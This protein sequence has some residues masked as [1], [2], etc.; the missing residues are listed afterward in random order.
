MRRTISLLIILSIVLSSAFS[1]AFDDSTELP[2]PG[3]DLG[4]IILAQNLTIS[5][6]YTVSGS[7]TWGHVVVTT[8]GK[9]VVPK[10][11]VLNGTSILLKGNSIL[12]VS[13]GKVNLT[14]SKKSGSVS[15]SGSCKH[16]NVTKGGI[17][18]LKGSNGYADTS[19]NGPYKSYISTSMGGSAK[20]DVIAST[21]LNLA[22]ATIIASGGDGF[23]LP[24]STSAA[25]NAWQKG[26][27][28]SGYAASGGNSSIWMRT[29]SPNAVKIE[30]SVLQASAG[31]GGDASKGGDG[32][33][34]APGKG[35]GYCNGGTVQGHV[36]AGGNADVSLCVNASLSIEHTNIT[37]SAGNGGKAGDGGK[38]GGVWSGGGGGG[39][40]GGDATNGASNAGYG[41]AKGDVGSGGDASLKIESTKLVITYCNVT[42]SG[43]TGGEAGDGGDGNNEGGGGGAGYGGGGGIGRS[44]SGKVCGPG[45]AAERVGTGGSATL[46]LVSGHIKIESSKLTAKAGNGGNAGDGGDGFWG[47]GFNGGGGGGGG[48]GGGGGAGDNVRGAKGSVTN[49]VGVGGSSILKFN[50]TTRIY[51]ISSTLVAVGGNGGGSGNGGLGPY[52]GG[53]GGGYGGAGGGSGGAYNGGSCTVSGTVGNGGDATLLLKG[54]PC[55]GPTSKLNCT[56][57]KKGDGKTSKGGGNCG[58]AGTGR[59]TS[60]GK[61]Y[62]TIPMCI[63]LLISPQNGSM[64]SPIFRYFAHNSTT[65][66]TVTGYTIQVDNDQN[67]SSPVISKTTKA[68]SITIANLSS[69]TYYWRVRAYYSS[70]A[71]STAGWSDV[72]IFYV[73]IN[74]PPRLVNPLKDFTMLEDTVDNTSVNLTGIFSDPEGD[75]LRYSVSGATNI[76]V[77]ILSN[78]SVVFTPDQDWTGVEEITFK[79]KDPHYHLKPDPIDTVN[80][81]VQNVN[82]PP[83]IISHDNINSTEDE[84]YEVQYDAEDID[85]TNDTLLW[86]MTSNSTFLIIDNATGLL[87]GTPRNDDV[88][89]FWVNITVSDGN[90]GYDSSNFTLTVF[91]TNDPPEIITSH[92][93]TCYENEFYSVEYTATDIDPTADVFTW[94]LDTTCFF[95]TMDPA[96]ILFGKPSN[97][98]VGNHHVSISVSDGK[99]GSTTS[100]FTLTVINVNDAP[101]ITTSPRTTCMEDEHYV[102]DFE[103][104]DIDPTADVFEWSIET[105]ASFLTIDP[106]EGVLSGTPENDDVGN[107][108]VSVRVS[109]GRGG[110][111]VVNFTLAVFNVND[112]PVILTEDCT[113]CLEDESYSVDYEAVDLDPTLDKL[114][115]GMETNAS[116]LNMDPQTGCLTGVP[117]NWDVGDYWVK[118]IVSDG[119]GGLMT[120][121][122]FLT[123]LAVNDPPIVAKVP[124]VVLRED[125]PG[126]IDLSSHVSDEDTPTALLNLT[127]FHYGIV[128]VSG[129]ELEMLYEVWLEDHLVTFNVSDGESSVEGSF[130]VRVIGINDPPEI[131]GL[132]PHSPPIYIV[133]E[134]GTELWLPIVFEDEDD[135]Q[136]HFGVT[137]QWN[138]VQAYDNGTVRIQ[139]KKGELG[140][141]EATVTVDDLKG[142]FATIDLT[143]EVIN[144]NDPPSVKILSPGNGTMYEFGQNVTFNARISDPDIVIGDELTL[145]WTS[146]ISGTL[147]SL[148]LEDDLEFRLNGLVE[149][150]HRITATVSDGNLSSSAWLDLT[151]VKKSEPDE[152]DE[153]RVFLRPIE[154]AI[155]VLIII[156]TA[157]LAI[158]RVYRRQSTVEDDMVEPQPEEPHTEEVESSDLEPQGEDDHQDIEIE[159]R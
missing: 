23:D 86:A 25:C 110:F 89:I 64:L 135:D 140:Q 13:G 7:E 147:K 49:K 40:C 104:R 24:K 77:T 18:L 80:V 19:S 134:E 76:S 122:F 41:Y 60:D 152:G 119:I 124:M 83:R 6:V 82:D 117:D 123:V 106:A 84:P 70:P 115:W 125:E 8:S 90:G 98:D 105:E 55:I 32:A 154:L 113:T 74:N 103:A 131:R 45:S 141:F 12:E 153:P 61:E 133:M 155:I 128:E 157:L 33:V 47:G 75:R 37:A 42:A 16:F 31:D 17:I 114:F 36:G 144:V 132:G 87:N 148:G 158:W 54:T 30:W 27:T 79:A 156:L 111:D 68:G 142:G 29:R 120:S 56:K 20:I 34:N 51:L 21:G 136:F 58:G 9:L 112:P 143:V 43:G 81:T 118:V 5:N 73:G 66:G 59:T 145:T 127:C 126:V 46:D 3:G 28:L 101:I 138:G 2:S 38:A 88:G 71:N 93:T 130:M 94:D 107:H 69:G 15:L 139:T 159:F 72:F 65:H 151:I 26:G 97:D 121:E 22:N 129:L 116:F 108:P 35:G 44:N 14:N 149:G 95:L 39:Y 10:G 137:S 78:G 99:G 92:R 67:F 109:D 48:F 50:S 11:T 57:G 85:P 1:L 100:N 150:H 63:P 53:G 96:G 102:V 4:S 62:K 91:N 52:G 146:N